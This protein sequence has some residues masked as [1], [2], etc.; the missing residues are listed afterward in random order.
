MAEAPGF[1]QLGGELA[2]D[3]DIQFVSPVPC[4]KGNQALTRI[5]AEHTGFT[6][7]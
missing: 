2:H 6:A 4:A 3:V 1:E 7:S 5:C